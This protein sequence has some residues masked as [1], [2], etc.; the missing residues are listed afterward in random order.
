MLYPEL[1]TPCVVIDETRT[2]QNIARFQ[3]YC[4]EYGIRLR[5]HIKTHKLTYLARKQVNAGAQ[6][7]CC[8]KLG[9]AEVFAAAGFD[10]ILIS[11]N[12]VGARKL[13]RLRELAERVRQLTVVADSVAVLQGLSTA[14]AATKP[15]GVMIECDTGAGRC[16][17]RTPAEVVAL[18]RQVEA[19]PGLQLRGLMTYPQPFMEER[20]QQWLQ[21]AAAY[22]AAEGIRVE[23][24]SSGGTPSM[25][26]AHKAPIV[27]EYRAGTY[28]YQDRS[29]IAQGAC[30]E[31]DCALMVLST[32]VSVPAP[33]RVIIDAGSKALTSDLLGQE[34]Y[35]QIIGHPQARITSLSEE[36]G[37][38]SV[39]PTATF[40]VGERLLILPNHAC[41]VSNLFDQVHF[42][43]GGRFIHSQQV[44]ARGKVY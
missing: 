9:E 1:D 10:D 2:E 5:P 8:Q 18:A 43:R 44:E 30:T 26:Y 36:H 17:V 24:F 19:L 29:Q 28:V 27:N 15:L 14:F 35:G 38:L 41:P 39:P 31:Q 37:I 34:G 13:Q 33:G 6:G 21:T 23:V 32:V 22:C 7:I 12:I 40:T 25:W 20:V 16:G 4:D 11:Y 3:R 42:C